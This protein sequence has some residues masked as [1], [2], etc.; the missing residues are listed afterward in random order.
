MVSHD[1]RTCTGG[2]AQVAALRQERKDDML[3]R[4]TD[5]S[6]GTFRRFRQNCI[7]PLMRPALVAGVAVHELESDWEGAPQR[8]GRV[9]NRDGFFVLAPITVPLQGAS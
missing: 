8:I 9:V 2:V 4:G 1:R 7:A 6:Q 3:Q 5:E